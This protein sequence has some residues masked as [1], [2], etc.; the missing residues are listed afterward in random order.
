MIEMEVHNVAIRFHNQYTSLLDNS[1][2][3]IPE[4]LCDRVSSGA[5]YFLEKLEQFNKFYH[6]STLSSN[7]KR[8]ERQLANV[9]ETLEDI[10]QTKMRL[11]MYASKKHFSI[12]GYLEAKA[13]IILS[14]HTD[15][16]I[17]QKKKR[18]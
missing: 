6:S 17:N 5:S 10:L 13:C 14:N 16:G 2:D 7:N 18:I 1:S 12:E 11:L 4:E 9:R 8:I 3:L 15:K